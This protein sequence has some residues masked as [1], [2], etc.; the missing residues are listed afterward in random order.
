[1]GSQRL[2]LPSGKLAVCYGKSPSFFRWTNEQNVKMGQFLKQTL[3]NY[4]RIIHI[5]MNLDLNHWF[6]PLKRQNNHNSHNHEFP[7]KS[8]TSRRTFC[9]WRACRASSW[10]WAR[11]M[12]TRPFRWPR[13]WISCRWPR[14]QVRAKWESGQEKLG[15]Y[16][17]VPP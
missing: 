12:D 7:M 17:V 1:M 11:S 5:P 9:T 8:P 10:R 15:I 13:S 6:V 16:N 2:P 14:P 4:Q 3:T